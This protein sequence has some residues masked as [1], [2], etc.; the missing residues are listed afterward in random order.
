MILNTHA[1]ESEKRDPIKVTKEIKYLSQK[2]A[3]DYLYLYH[4]SKQAMVRDTLQ[5]SI[6]KLEDSFRFLAKNTTNDDSKNILDFLSYNKDQ[7]KEI[8]AVDISSENATSIM[9]LSDTLLEGAN[10]ILDT[11]IDHTSEQKFHLM[12]ISKL[13]MAVN[14]GFDPENNRE[15]LKQE[16]V[17]FSHWQSK[18][19]WRAFKTI[20]DSKNCF[21]PNITSIL[22]K[23]LENGLSKI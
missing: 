11:K 1:S 9:D 5:E 22:L 21:V 12:K 19:S 6:K 10:S 23:D 4:G 17:L 15:Q 7:I 3:N 20:L 16:M 18:Q 8:L 2:I 13:F 14:L